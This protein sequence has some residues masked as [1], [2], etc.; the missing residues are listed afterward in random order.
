MFTTALTLTILYWAIALSAAF[1]LLSLIKRLWRYRQV[2]RYTYR[3]LGTFF[4]LA[5]IL[6]V[7]G[8]LPEPYYSYTAYFAAGLLLIPALLLF[9]A[10]ASF[11]LYHLMIHGNMFYEAP[12]PGEEQHRV[13][14][15][16]DKKKKR[17]P[18]MCPICKRRTYCTLKRSDD[19]RIYVHVVRG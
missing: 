2:R 12:L 7:S 18:E 9:L 8:I 19:G 15:H 5:F 10:Q 17:R 14:M 6:L 11:W 4:A 13:F 1:G 3:I 16:D